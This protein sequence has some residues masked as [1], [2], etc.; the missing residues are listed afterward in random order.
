MAVT[1]EHA[2]SASP[3]THL[4]SIGGNKKPGEPSR[5]NLDN[6]GPTMPK[7]P[8]ARVASPGAALPGAPRLMPCITQSRSKPSAPSHDRGPAPS[9]SML[10]VPSKMSSAPDIGV[11]RD[12]IISHGKLEGT[13]AR[14]PT[15]AADD[16]TRGKYGDVTKHS[17]RRWT[18]GDA[19]VQLLSPNHH[20]LSQNRNRR[21]GNGINQWTT[22]CS[23]REETNRKD[24]GRAFLDGGSAPPEPDEDDPPLRPW[25]LH[26]PARMVGPTK[27]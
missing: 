10:I 27:P 22:P 2:N 18:I 24:Q 8:R 16:A 23:Y 14:L 17:T 7:Y 20:L 11:C 12:I 6:P 25:P 1:F 26:Q 21:S 13:R 19:E 5:S 9:T 3:S 15:L 4:Q